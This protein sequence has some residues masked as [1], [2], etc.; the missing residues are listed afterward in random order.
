MGKAHSAELAWRV[1]WYALE[2]GLWREWM[3]W[4]LAHEI[5]ESALWVSE[6]YAQTVW[7]RF[8]WT[9]D[10]ETHQGGREAEPSN[11]TWTYE[12]DYKLIESVPS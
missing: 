4:E 8:W 10:V 7:E 11:K 6:H 3:P 5:A 2:A 1:V 9:G 12:E